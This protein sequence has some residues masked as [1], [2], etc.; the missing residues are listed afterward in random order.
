M[1]DW[2]PGNICGWRSKK[3]EEAAFEEKVEMMLQK[4]FCYVE[5]PMRHAHH[6]F[7]SACDS[8]ALHELKNGSA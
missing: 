7:N 4:D 3:R 5:Y 2:V 1:V 8:W 6:S